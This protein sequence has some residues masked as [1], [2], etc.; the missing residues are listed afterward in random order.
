M[1]LPSFLAECWFKGRTK[2]H[3]GGSVSQPSFFAVFYFCFRWKLFPSPKG[4]KWDRECRER[5]SLH[6][7]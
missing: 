3:D 4:Q 2:R 6:R 7:E 1:F 5:C